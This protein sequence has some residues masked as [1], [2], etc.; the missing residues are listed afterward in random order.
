MTTIV[1]KFFFIQID[2]YC[3]LEGVFVRTKLAIQLIISRK[4]II[5]AF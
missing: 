1:N 2:N 4:V 5:S 3:E